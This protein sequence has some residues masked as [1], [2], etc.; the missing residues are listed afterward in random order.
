MTTLIYIRSACFELRL[1]VL[2][3]L[4]ELA[5]KNVSEQLNQMINDYSSSKYTDLIVIS[6]STPIAFS[7]SL[8]KSD[9]SKY[10]FNDPSVAIS[11]VSEQQINQNDLDEVSYII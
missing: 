4:Q 9:V 5:K 1:L 10:V 8:K 3:R 11:L 7:F 6:S 2:L